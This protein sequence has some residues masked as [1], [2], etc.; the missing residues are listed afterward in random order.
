LAWI[1]CSKCRKTKLLILADPPPL[2]KRVLLHPFA[3]PLSWGTRHLLPDGF[4]D[5]VPHRS[6]LPLSSGPVLSYGF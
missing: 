1:S 6:A 3:S 5:D 2:A 4:S